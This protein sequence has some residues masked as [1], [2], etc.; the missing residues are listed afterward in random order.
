LAELS[1][2]FAGESRLDDAVQVLQEASNLYKEANASSKA[3]TVLES[4]ADLLAE[5]GE[6]IGAA[7]FSCEVSEIRLSNQITQGSSGSVFVKAMILQIQSND[8]V[9]AKMKLDKNGWYSEEIG[10]T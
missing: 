8:T 4:V 5:K 3:A 1:K 9:G 7:K 6:L 2:V 10:G